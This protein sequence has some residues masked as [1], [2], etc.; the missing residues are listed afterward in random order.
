MK[1][2]FFEARDNYLVMLE[3]SRLE[4]V[5]V[6]ELARAKYQTARDA[7]MI[8]LL[9]DILRNLKEVEDNTRQ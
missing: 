7:I 3:S 9:Q 4:Q 2:D 8:E 5:R 1:S 6:F